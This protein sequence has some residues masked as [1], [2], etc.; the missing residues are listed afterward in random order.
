VIGLRNR[1]GCINITFQLVR[2]EEQVPD[3]IDVAG[4]AASKL[5][6][7]AVK[8][9]TGTSTAGFLN[10]GPG[11][12]PPTA[13]PDA[14]KGN[15]TGVWGFVGELVEAPRQANSPPLTCG[16]FGQSGTVDLTG[17]TGAG[18]ILAGA[19]LAIT[20]SSPATGTAGV[21]GFG[22]IYGVLGV[23]PVSGVL[24]VG[25]AKGAGVTGNS[26]TSGDGVYGF[27]NNGFGVHGANNQGSAPNGPGGPGIQPGNGCGVFGESLQFEGVFGASGNQHGVHGVNGKGSGK[28]PQHGAGVWGD[29]ENGFGVYGASKNS[30]AG[31]FDGDV[32]ITGTQTVT[33]NVAVKGN[34]TVSGNVSVAGD[35][36][37]TT[38]IASGADCAE[39]F[40]LSGSITAEA[41]TVMVI[42][43]DGALRPSDCA[44][45][46]RVAG[47][48]SGAGA[49]RPGLILDKRADDEGRTTIALVGKVY[50]KV[51]ADSVP[52]AVGDL[53]TTSATSGHA[54]K[55]V[56]PKRAF[57]AVIGKALLPM[58]SGQG[59]LP[60]LVS[61]Q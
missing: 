45:D 1:S 38:A 47:V 25:T 12:N 50:C 14:T 30:F 52:I 8:T 32:A 16:V 13:L 24:G 48:V 54:M 51:D 20:A 42:G 56:D 9:L 28:S 15:V 4:S 60:I 53:L 36:L 5:S 61:L 18:E 49:F 11:S 21:V 59:L 34:H 31:Q 2:M 17:L 23:G 7:G 39:R 10:V 58:M 55:A 41:G 57:G 22:S 6:S 27:S 44:Y 35:V 29:S 33:G 37:L 26:A 3:P 46:R 43:E 19:G 40:D